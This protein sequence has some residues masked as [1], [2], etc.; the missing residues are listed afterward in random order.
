MVKGVTVIKAW[1]VEGSGYYGSGGGIKSMSDAAKI[2][3]MV[4][5][6]LE[7]DEICLERQ[8]RVKYETEIFGRQD[9]HYGLGGREGERG[10][11]YFRRLLRETDK[12]EF[13]FRGIESK[14]VRRHS[15]RD[16]SDS[17]LRLL[18]ERVC[19]DEC[20]FVLMWG[21]VEDE[22]GSGPTSEREGSRGGST[23]REEWWEGCG[24]QWL[25]PKWSW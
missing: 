6:A 19:L 16:E 13:S 15:R 1:M 23:D 9:E 3:N 12:K 18:Q 7:R 8:R 14:I 22:Q 17:G 2:A 11:D 4:W 20:K 24:G 5:Q 10:V 21:T 25:N